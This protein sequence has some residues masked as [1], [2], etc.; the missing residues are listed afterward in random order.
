MN[1]FNYSLKE[2]S[3]TKAMLWGNFRE[4]AYAVTQ[5]GSLGHRTVHL[6]IAAAEVLPIIGQIVSLAEMIL[7]SRLK[8]IQPLNPTP[9]EERKAFEAMKT[10]FDELA[11]YERDKYVLTLEGE[12]LDLAFALYERFVDKL[13][14][15]DDQVR[16][17][18]A[19]KGPEHKHYGSPL[20][21][22][23]EL[24]LKLKIIPYQQR[25]TRLFD[26][27]Y[28]INASEGY[29]RCAE[30][31]ESVKRNSPAYNI[32]HLYYL[33]F[34]EHKSKESKKELA[35]EA[36]YRLIKR[37]P[38]YL[39]EKNICLTIKQLADLEHPEALMSYA[40]SIFEASQ[41]FDISPEQK[42]ALQ[43]QFF[44]LSSKAAKLEIPEG[45]NYLGYCYYNGVGVTQDKNKGLE[46][47]QRASALGNENAKRTLASLS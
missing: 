1:N 19:S 18:T 41:K 3:F 39:K 27:A 10:V 22:V 16:E 6:I 47:Y 13:F 17:R 28:F 43:I 9:S 7:V 15:W 26:F 4:H 23:C 25:L 8:S 5:K 45:T 36:G 31:Y 37:Y 20:L 30:Y 33:A 29:F 2:Y 38:N 24:Y 32:P 40:W 42:K 12:K 44:E 35:L 11:I 46:W 21:T 14:A 34:V